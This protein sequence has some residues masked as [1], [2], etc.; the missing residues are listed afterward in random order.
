MDIINKCVNGKTVLV[1]LIIFCS[2]SNYEW[3]TIEQGGICLY[4][5]ARFEGL[6]KCIHQLCLYLI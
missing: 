2:S 3:P 6:V 4:Q 5:G 1:L